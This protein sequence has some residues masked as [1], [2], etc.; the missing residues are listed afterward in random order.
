[1]GD[2]AGGPAVNG[3]AA[4]ADAR[5][6]THSTVADA[7]LPRRPR[8]G[9]G[10]HAAALALVLV[11]VLP[12]VGTHGLF[13]A[14]EGAVLAQVRL[15]R[16]HHSWTQAHPF[17]EADPTGDAFPLD[18]SSRSGDQYAPFAKHPVY[19]ALLTAI[20]RAGGRAAMFL[21]SVLG[22][23][24]A[25]LL[26]ALLARRLGDGLARPTLW[27]VGLASPLVFDGYLLIGHSLG[28]AASAGFVLLILVARDRRGWAPLAGAL[29]CL[30]V[31]GLLRNEVQLLAVAAAIVLAVEAVRRRDRFAGV[32]AGAV[33]LT[34]AVTFAVDAKLTAA[35][36][37]GAPQAFAIGSQSGNLVTDRLFAAA[38]TLLVP[39]YGKFG[40]GD[41]LAVLAAAVALFG[42]FIARTRPEDSEGITVVF[43]TAAVASVAR[44]FF[45]AGAVPGLV[46][47]FPLLAVGLVSLRRTDVR[48][49]AARLAGIAGLF[50]AAVLAT[51]YRSG[52]SGEWGA[53]YLAA[54]LPV[55]VPLVALG[56][57]RI[58]S[59][60]AAEPSRRRAVVVALVALAVA[61]AV[62]AVATLRSSHR[63]TVAL[64][65]AI[66]R[67][68][69]TT[70]PGDGGLPVVLTTAKATAR[71]AYPIL[72]DGR[73]LTVPADD[74]G[75]YADRVSTLVPG[76]VV[77]VTRDLESDAD[78]LDSRFRV[79]EIDEL[80][81]GWHI[82]RLDR[83]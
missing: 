23:V 1:M 18:L 44:L 69:N 6:A 22:T 80:H 4:V 37:G 57:R 2:R 20:D 10:L 28:A 7:P 81:G 30:V 43:C 8:F 46:V 39:S 56:L 82:L 36:L 9:L 12:V 35:A 47:A 13:S 73:W 29:A 59:A 49:D 76:S 63:E 26:A 70:D 5:P 45:P 74:L 40:V 62:L 60:L 67:A 64:V 54:G 75:A 41:V 79:T 11:A 32:L 50:A 17:P 77:F 31:G 71:F 38:L 27:L 61:P 72:D 16:E 65:A 68:A 66:D 53:R 14:D 55:V 42:A 25:A 52:G 15:L 58:P 78:V 24:L 48:G 3:V 83:K 33:V 34:G 19:P 51:Q 21:T